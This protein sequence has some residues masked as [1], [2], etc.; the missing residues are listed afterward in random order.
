MEAV[1]DCREEK[2]K[3]LLL[4]PR[5]GLNPKGCWEVGGIKEESGQVGV[6]GHW[7]SVAGVRI[8]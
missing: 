1:L 6:K 7:A 4:S 3:Y 2:E 5:L 8:L